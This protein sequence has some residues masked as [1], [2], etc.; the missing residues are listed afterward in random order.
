MDTNEMVVAL[1]GLEFF[2]GVSDAYLLELATCGSP[3]RFGAGQTIFRQQGAAER[4]YVLMDG[5]IAVSLETPDRGEVTI[6]TLVAGD[7]LGW[8][9]LFPPHIWHF[10]ARAVAETAVIAFDGPCIRARCDADPAL[11][12]ELM[13]RFSRVVVRRLQASR[14]QL[15]DMFSSASDV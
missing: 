14:A 13:K 8:S 11:G 6:Q 3:E 10:D 9:W 15:T 12:Y 1:K 2:E 5:R 7:V 4:F